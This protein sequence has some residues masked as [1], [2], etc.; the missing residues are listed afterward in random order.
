MIWL[1]QNIAAKDLISTQQNYNFSAHVFTSTQLNSHIDQ[2][3]T[4]KMQML[5]FITEVS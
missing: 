2:I 1:K 4:S 3:A 5:K